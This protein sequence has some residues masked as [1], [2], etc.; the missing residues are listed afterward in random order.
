M[1]EEEE[2]RLSLEATKSENSSPPSLNKIKKRYKQMMNLI[3]LLCELV[4]L[5]V[6]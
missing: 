1:K 4:L 3:L 6:N 5:Q 2:L